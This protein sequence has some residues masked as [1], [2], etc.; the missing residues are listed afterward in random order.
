[1]LTIRAMSGGAGYAQRHLEHSDYYDEHRRVQGEWHGRGAELLGLRGEVAQKQF[2]AVREGLHPET[3][4]FL[5]PRHSADRISP[6]GS[7]QSKGR[8]L[9]DLT[10]SAPKSVS[11]QALVGGDE[12]LTEAHD[13]AVREAL[14]E[15]ESHAATRVRL[16]GANEDR[17]TA[18]WTVATY[19]HDTSR[20]LDPQLHT[21]SVAAN[22]T[23]DG[24]EGRWKALQ[25]SGL[26]ERRAYLTEVYRNA[27]AREV[28]GLG[29]EIEPRRDS[30]GK[31]HG[32]EI[33]GVSNEL[34]EKYSVRSAQRDA[35]VERFT[36]EHG[37]KPTDNEVAV[38][39]RESRADKLAEIVT[40]KVREQQQARLAPEE[41]HTLQHLRAESLA[42]NPRILH[43]SSQASE[44]LQYAKEHLFERNSVVRDHELMTEALRHGRG[45]IDPGQLRGAL[46]LEQSQ[47]SLIRAGNNLATRE[48]LE[49]EQRM[50]AAVD[51]GIQRFERLGGEREFRPSERLRE[52]QQRAVHQVLDSRDFSINLRGAAGTGKTAALHEID[53]GLHD[54]GRDVVAVAPTRSAVEELRK[55]GF[56][57]A[58]TI[59]RLLDSPEQ[60]SLHGK[61]LVVDEAGMVSGRQMED[62]LK[63][64]EREHARILFSGDTRQIQSVEASDALRILERESQ[65]KSVSLMG[66]QRQ[67]QA[68]YRD[69]IQTLRQSPEQGFEK[70]EQLGAVREVPFMERAQ[71]VASA[72]R[73][74]TSDP[75]CKVL[76]V[77]GTH[78]E[79][80]RI[81]H[82]IRDDMKQRGELE[83]GIVF[84]RH[85]P[86]QWTEAQKKD[87]SNYQEGQVLLFHRSSHGIGRHE[88]LT[89][90]HADTSHIVARDQYGVER[91]VSPTQAR[92]FS[93][94]ERQQIEVAPGDRLLL[95]GNR[96]EADFRATNGELT[97][98]RGVDG[99]RIQLEDGRT[100]PANYREFNHGY[101]ITAHRSQGKTVDAVVLSGDMM[102]RE[103]F[104]VAASR[105][106]DGI[107]IITSDVDHLR[108]SLGISSARPSATELAREQAQTHPALEHG[109]AH[110]PVQNVEPP[111]PQHDFT[112]GHDLGMS[113]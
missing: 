3:G 12:R 40:E 34:L 55:V 48:S 103:Q 47:G 111:A 16:N 59:S 69:A 91:I 37:R 54:A 27:L 6:D 32:F 92:S 33:R 101:A 50:I 8:S 110:L 99:G 77:A 25:A 78:E 35:A 30:K 72:Y 22:L 58:M 24:A 4:E 67:T 57:D 19:R 93:V 83:R 100:L 61:V 11:I 1:M 98:V 63:L 89:V 70:L 66:V 43:E 39:V 60:A 46:E 108:E 21:H 53:R 94:H 17:V 80:G 28:R 26:Y 64:A 52:E 23:Y 74:L 10:F 106:R 75:H 36:L 65:M 29:Y 56:N 113:L 45:Q 13:K 68:E 38:L 95:T 44:S 31:D 41:K 62:L 112:H 14:A 86:L 107:T 5:R 20:E 9:Y 84:E 79:I 87:L 97:K 81:T 102:K 7:E 96:R 49:R 42:Q 76:V 18:N 2:E 85:I 88:S 71:A 73:E 109:L 90:E 82:A 15:G 105:G 51:R 104:Y